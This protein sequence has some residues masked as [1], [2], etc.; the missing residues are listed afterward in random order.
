MCTTCMFSKAPAL[1]R[2]ISE[3]YPI[4]YLYC[5]TGIQASVHLIEVVLITE[6]SIILLMVHCSLMYSYV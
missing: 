4:V 3:A 2:N 5:Y 1:T 6:V